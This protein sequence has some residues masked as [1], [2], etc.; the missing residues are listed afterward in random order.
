MGATGEEPVQPPIRV[1]SGVQGALGCSRVRV[2]AG[3]KKAN[4]GQ[5]VS[6]LTVTPH[7]FI[8]LP[9]SLQNR[10]PPFYT[11]SKAFTEIPYNMK[12]KK[13]IRMEDDF[14]EQE[15]FDKIQDLMCSTRLPWYYINAIVATN[16]ED[17]FKFFH[18]FHDNEV[19]T[20]STF[21][22]ELNPI[23]KRIQPMS[24]HRIKANLL[25]RTP[26]IVENAFH[27]DLLPLADSQEK[28]KQWTT[29]IFYVNTNNGYTK[30]EDGTQVE[31]VA[32]RMVTFPANLQH[33]GTSCTDE[34]TRI[35]INFN[36]FEQVALT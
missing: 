2:H 12:I 22:Y 7:Q 26:N 30:F 28:L 29:S 1:W 9:I 31:S 13:R 27:T 21:M 14:L 34:R 15:D 24:L 20:H 23:L 25:T 18:M 8:P 32:N 11:A 36:Y 16:D 35:V 33:C 10:V 3:Y 19:Y 6:N 17:R 4:N 5:K